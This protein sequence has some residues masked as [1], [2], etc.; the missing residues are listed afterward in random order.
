MPGAPSPPPIP[1]QVP[2]H[3]DQGALEF[4]RSPAM[5]YTLK[6]TLVSVAFILLLIVVLFFLLSQL[7]FVGVGILVAALALLV[8]KRRIDYHGRV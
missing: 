7:W 3:S 8:V 2:P 4:E 1:W 5:G 6:G